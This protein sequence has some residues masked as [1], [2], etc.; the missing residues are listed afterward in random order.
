MK[1]VIG[2]GAIGG[3]LFGIVALVLGLTLL[4]VILIFATV[5]M[6]LAFVLY[7]TRVIPLTIVERI[8]Y[9]FKP[10]RRQRKWNV[11]TKLVRAIQNISVKIAQ[12]AF[13]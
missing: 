1:K 5:L 13:V 6:A 4:S 11:N 7:Y 10:K 9:L 2:L 8:N 3:V 12:V